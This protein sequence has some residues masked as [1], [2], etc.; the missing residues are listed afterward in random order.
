[1]VPGPTRRLHSLLSADKCMIPAVIPG[2]HFFGYSVRPPQYVLPTRSRTIISGAAA[3][4]APQLHDLAVL[5]QERLTGI[6]L[7]SDSFL[8]NFAN[9]RLLL[10]RRVPLYP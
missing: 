3:S 8:F 7:E 4:S 10:R 5:P 6:L 9:N 1:M 2:L